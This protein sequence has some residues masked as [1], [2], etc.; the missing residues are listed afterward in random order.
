MQTLHGRIEAAA[1]EAKRTG[2]LI[3]VRELPGWPGVSVWIEWFDGAYLCSIELGQLVLNNLLG[4]KQ[5]KRLGKAV[6][7]EWLDAVKLQ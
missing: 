5:A 4:Y 1:V 7:R 2:D 3:V 6:E